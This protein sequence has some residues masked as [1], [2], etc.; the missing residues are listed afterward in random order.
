MEEITEFIE[1]I[2]LCQHFYKNKEDAIL[3]E[4]IND[5]EKYSLK[6]EDIEYIFEIK[7]G[8]NG[9]AKVYKKC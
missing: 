4:I 1:S 8:N 7:H 3:I 6:I 9:Y 5:V 2:L